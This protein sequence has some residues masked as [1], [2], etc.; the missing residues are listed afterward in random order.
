MRTITLVSAALGAAFFMSGCALFDR[1]IEPATGAVA[2]GIDRA[3]TEG[4]SPLGVE[5][6][7]EIVAA[8]NAKT[9]VGNHTPSDCD[10]DGLP[11]FEIDADGIP[12]PA[13]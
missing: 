2:R 10:S 5:A 7:R 12:V 1:V 6:R 11:D 3:C 4:T 9:M 13:S 8:I